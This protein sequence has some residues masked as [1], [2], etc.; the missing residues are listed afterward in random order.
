MRSGVDAAALAVLNAQGTEPH[1]LI[2]IELPT[3]TLHFTDNRAVTVDTVPYQPGAIM[4]NLRP[5]KN[6]G[7]DARLTLNNGDGAV[8][9][10][11]VQVGTI[12]H[13]VTGYAYYPT[14]TKIQLFQGETDGGGWNR[15]RVTLN[16]RLR[17]G[18]RGR[19]PRLTIGPP[20]MNWLPSPGSEIEW[21]GERYVYEG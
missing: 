20:M 6:G 4:D 18:Q 5:A 16:V 12:G 11:F 3:G 21:D 17:A 2:D 19:L 13:T 15:Q 10:L 14:L 1:V 8:S 9:P 7:F